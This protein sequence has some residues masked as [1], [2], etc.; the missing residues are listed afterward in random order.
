MIDYKKIHDSCGW[1]EK[2]ILRSSVCGCFHCISL[3]T[4]AEIS[5]WIDEPEDCPRGK[6]RTALCP[7]CG[8]DSVL[9]DTID[10]G[11]TLDLLKEMNGEYF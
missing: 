3:F 6:G 2:E 11:L 4:P 7:K 1:H 10:G 8:I 9:P 5:E